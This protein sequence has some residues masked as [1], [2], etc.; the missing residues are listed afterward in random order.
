MGGIAGRLW[1]SS[2]HDSYSRAD[3]S[4]SSD[5]VGGIV[6]YMEQGYEESLVNTYATGD[7][8]GS[9]KVGGLVGETYSEGEIKNSFAVGSVTATVGTVGGL[10][11]LYGQNTEADWPYASYPATTV[12]NSYWY[13]GF[14]DSCAGDN[15]VDGC[16]AVDDVSELYDAGHSVYADW[17]FVDVWEE[18]DGDYPVLSWEEDNLVI[19]ITRFPVIK[20]ETEN[21]TIVKLKI[22]SSENVMAIKEIFIPED[23]ATLGIYSDPEIDI[24]EVNKAEQTFVIADRSE[25]LNVDMYYFLSYSCD[26]DETAGEFFVLID[27]DQVVSGS[28]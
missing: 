23:C 19:N 8:V 18:R 2:I 13:S 10:V 6:G 5:E 17:D 22:I 9:N 25:A 20:N 27:D 11:G 14:V 12:S 4:G 21:I 3:V 16:Y 1:S 26:V 28:F 7:V 24:L 15:P